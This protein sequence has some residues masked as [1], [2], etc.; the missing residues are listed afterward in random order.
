MAKRETHIDD[1]MRLIGAPFN[2]VHAWLDSYAAKF[3][4][5]IHCEY[6]RKF[7]HHRKGVVKC[8][9]LFGELG[10]LAAKIHIIRDVEIYVIQKPFREVMGDWV[11]SPS[12]CR[13]LMNPKVEEMGVARHSKYWVQHFGKKLPKDTTRSKRK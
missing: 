7:R 5:H 13:M 11:D 1:C 2:D 8:K 6:H 4:P 10:E 3:P 9:E 12:H